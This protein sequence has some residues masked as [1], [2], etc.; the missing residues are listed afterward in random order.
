[1]IVLCTPNGLRYPRVGGLRE[2]HFAGANFKPRELLENAQTPTR[3]VHAVLGA[4]VGIYPSVFSG[5]KL[6]NFN[7]E[8]PVKPAIGTQAIIV[9]N[10]QRILSG[11]ENDSNIRYV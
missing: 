2:R 8:K 7:K 6:F 11:I 1:M 9:C 5:N 3:R 4:V 10:N